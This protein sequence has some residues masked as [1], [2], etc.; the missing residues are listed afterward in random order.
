MTVTEAL[1]AAGIDVTRD[2]VPRPGR[3]TITITAAQAAVW[4]AEWSRHAGVTGLQLER[5]YPTAPD[6]VPLSALIGAWVAESHTAAAKAARTLMDPLAAGDPQYFRFPTAVLA[7]FVQDITSTAPADTDQ[8]AGF[9]APGSGDLDPCGMLSGLYDATIGKISSWFATTGADST[10]I[11]I[12]GE[13]LSLF[14][15]FLGKAV[16]TAL[17]PLLGPI[18]AAIGALGVATAVAGAL[19]PWTAEITAMPSQ[20]AFGILPAPGEKGTFTVTVTTPLPDWPVGVRSCASLVGV[21]LPSVSPAGSAVDWTFYDGA[22]AAEQRHD[23][24]LADGPAAA[25]SLDFVTG[26]ET[27]EDAKGSLLVDPVMVAVDVQR[28]TSALSVVL[29]KL[30]GSALDALPDVIVVLLSGVATDALTT[31]LTA[32]GAS[33][34]SDPVPVSHHLPPPSDPPAAPPAGQPPADTPTP[35]AEQSCVGADLVSQLNP[36]V[37][38]DMNTIMPGAVDL[39]LAPDHTGYFDFTDSTDF[40]AENVTGHVTGRITFHWTGGP[41]TFSTSDASGTLTATIKTM[42]TSNTIE[43]PAESIVQTGETMLCA[44]GDITIERTGWVFY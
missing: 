44:G 21:E 3:G 40:A 5:M 34:V 16:S 4:G 41:T 14:G 35:P 30:I 8:P 27:A 10:I 6:A 39:W 28:D 33:A 19:A 23:G 13:A 22:V 15:E 7:M 9:R 43:L 12:A 11:E 38:S 18:K 26:T 24:V 17:A 32:S 36:M 37:G 42:G 20:A 2:D 25:A 1:S 29:N 31:L